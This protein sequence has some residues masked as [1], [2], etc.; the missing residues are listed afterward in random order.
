MGRRVNNIHYIYKITCN[1]TGKWYIGMHSTNNLNDGYMGSGTIL[2]HSIRKHG[3]ENHTK[4]ILEYYNSREELAIREIEIVNKELIS[5]GKCMNLKE[6]GDG[7]FLNEEH[8]INCSKAGVKA[9]KEKLINDDDFRKM[10]SDNR[11]KVTKKS[12]LD[13]KMSPIKYDWNGK[14]HSE[15]TINKMSEIR[16]DS[17][18]GETNSQYGTCWVTKDSINKKINSIELESY[19]NDGWS[20]GRYTELTGELVK[21]SKL[22][23]SEVKIIKQLLLDDNISQLKI[24]ERFNCKPETISKIKRGIIWVNVI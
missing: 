8:M 4:E 10:I 13:G 20:K 21:N 15:E 16:K 24:A 6:G 14:T 3:K 5:D 12:Y 17:G 2:R 1:I 22:K 7:G 9:F 11:S 23:E 18:I 19:I